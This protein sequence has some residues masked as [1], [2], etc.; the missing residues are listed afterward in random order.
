[1]KP[2]D[3]L[4]KLDRIAPTRRYEGGRTPTTPLAL[5]HAERCRA[6]FGAGVSATAARGVLRY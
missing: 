2:A 5:S 3:N 1:M 4:I 6:N